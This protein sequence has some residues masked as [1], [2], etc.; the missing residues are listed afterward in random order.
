M[1]DNDWVITCDPKEMRKT[2]IDVVKIKG[3]P[4]SHIQDITTD[5][6]GKVLS[7]HHTKLRKKKRA[8]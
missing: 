5:G 3:K 2:V 7:I 1:T 6:T 8:L 4:G